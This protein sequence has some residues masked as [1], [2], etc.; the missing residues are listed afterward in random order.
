MCCFR[1]VEKE[2]RHSLVNLLLRTSE[3]TVAS[4]EKQGA[5]VFGIGY[6]HVWHA[7]HSQPQRII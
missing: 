6:L 4:E 7:L 1:H 2:S 3:R 5:G